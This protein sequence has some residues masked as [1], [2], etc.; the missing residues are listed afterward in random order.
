MSTAFSRPGLRGRVR[1]GLSRE[2]QDQVKTPGKNPLAV[3]ACV[4]AIAGRTRPDGDGYTAGVAALA[5]LHRRME[6]RCGN[7]WK[8]IHRDEHV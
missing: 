5:R 6:V 3:V 7:G 1:S 2:I 4:S 8:E